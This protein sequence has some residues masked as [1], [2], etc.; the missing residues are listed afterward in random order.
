[1]AS[2]WADDRFERLQLLTRRF[3]QRGAR[4]EAELAYA[5]CRRRARA[6]LAP[7]AVL[8]GGRA[9]RRYAG[10]R[11]RATGFDLGVRSAGYG[12]RPDKAGGPVA[13]SAAAVDEQHFAGGAMIG[14]AGRSP[15]RAVRR[16][17]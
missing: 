13:Q 4:A 10:D 17:H 16:D 6:V 15:H 12:E 7:F 5:W 14:L 2:R 1:M 11:R 9:R 3:E 8:L